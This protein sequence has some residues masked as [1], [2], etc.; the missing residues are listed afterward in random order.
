MVKAF[1]LIIIDSAGDLLP[2]QGIVAGINA[3]LKVQ[4]RPPFILDRAV[5]RMHMK[6]NGRTHNGKELMGEGERE[7][8]KRN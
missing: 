2:P 7:R 8:P 3:G 4:G 5:R 6:E 1:Q